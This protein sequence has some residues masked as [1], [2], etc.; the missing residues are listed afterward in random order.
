MVLSPTKII[1]D[2]SRTTSRI[3]RYAQGALL[4]FAVSSVIAGW[5][6]SK[7]GTII[8]VAVV[9]FG[10]MVALFGF[11]RMSKARSGFYSRLGMFLATVTLVCILSLFITVLVYIGSGKPVWLDRFFGYAPANAPIAALDAGDILHES[12][13]L[14]VNPYFK[15]DAM[16]R[17]RVF[18][19]DLDQPIKTEIVSQN[20]AKEYKITNL[21]PSETYNV[22]IDAKLGKR[23][24]IFADSSFV[25]DALDTQR[26]FNVNGNPVTA[27]YT[28]DMLANGT[29]NSDLAKVRFSDGESIGV[30]TYQGPV[31]NGQLDG[32]GELSFEYDD[33]F[34]Y[35]C[36]QNVLNRAGMDICTPKC[37]SIAFEQGVLDEASCTLIFREARVSPSSGVF[38]DKLT[39]IYQ[40]RVVAV[41]GSGFSI[42]APFEVSLDGEG[43]LTTYFDDGFDLSVGTFENN[44]LNGVAGRFSKKGKLEEGDFVDGELV[45]GNVYNHQLGGASRYSYQVAAAVPI[46]AVINLSPDGFEF[47][48]ARGS[49]FSLRSGFAG[50]FKGDNFVLSDQ[51]ERSRDDREFSR[52]QLHPQSVDCGNHEFFGRRYDDSEWF[53][54]RGI[55]VW[56]GLSYEETG[57]AIDVKTPNTYMRI[58]MDDTIRVSAPIFSDI[59]AVVVDGHAFEPIILM[60]G[61]ADLRAPLIY[62]A[63]CSANNVQF[64]SYETVRA[65]S[66]FCEP[67]AVGLARAYYCARADNDSFDYFPDRER[68]NSVWEWRTFAHTARNGERATFYGSATLSPDQDGDMFSIRLYCQRNEFVKSLGFAVWDRS[69]AINDEVKALEFQLSSSAR[70]ETFVTAP[71][72]FGVF[73]PL[74]RD[75]DRF[76]TWLAADELFSVEFSDL[77]G[78][79]H[80]YT[81]APND[82]ASMREVMV[83]VC[84]SL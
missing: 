54:N 23:F 80:L 17:I 68:R 16:I 43:V 76:L 32:I 31:V 21:Q 35:E 49:A 51:V 46:G 4:L 50:H 22:R 14:R 65:N 28:G 82:S 11:E 9:V 47:G 24:S 25:T 70:E 64:P 61:L 3:H 72:E 83:D 18:Q 37:D 7:L 79:E 48:K 73:A 53:H 36:Y 12:A 19:D 1:T 44:R 74:K 26:E 71:N 55:D 59:E 20:V 62:T 15:E 39:S 69:I 5:A 33:D 42:N 10:F 84:Y 78:N 66:N 77:N 52:A 60:R 27:F 30:W 58:S 75:F 56:K 6:G 81:F 13:V 41:E 63:A 67:M 29:P 2:P 34:Q 8:L 45:F 38:T 40:G 57:L